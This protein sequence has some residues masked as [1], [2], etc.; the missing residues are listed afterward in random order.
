MGGTVA[1]VPDVLLDIDAGIARLTLNRPDAANG[2]GQSLADALLAAAEEV[3]DRGDV[4]AVLLTG[5]GARFC[6]GGDVRSFATAED[7]GALIASI[8]TPL[9]AAIAILT[10]L[11][12]PIVTAVQGSAAGAGIG[13]VAASDLVVAAASAKFVL[14]YTGIGLTPDGSTSWFLPRL[15]GYR[16]AVELMLTNRALSAPEAL[17]A[18]LITEVVDDE[19]LTERAEELVT[20]LAGGPTKAY[21]TVKRLVAASANND[22]VTQMALEADGIAAAARTADGREGVAAFVGK[23]SPGF[24]GS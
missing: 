21:G 23:R 20:R 18:G 15:I 9:H 10:D 22:L 2:I 8:T 13:L 1:T 24:S 14:A 5:A 6:G 12:A 11:D 4:R 19:R 16:R 7:P 3:R 17:A